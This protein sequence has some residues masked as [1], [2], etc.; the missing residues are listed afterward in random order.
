MVLVLA[1]APCA[2]CRFLLSI[3]RCRRRQL[4]GA[5]ETDTV[6]VVLAGTASEAL[7][8]GS[9]LIG[10]GL[11]AAAVSTAGVDVRRWVFKAPRIH[12]SVCSMYKRSF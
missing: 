6:A 3:R 7:A 8:G 4:V 2:R 1:C 11:D 12:T 10:A 5:L 9:A